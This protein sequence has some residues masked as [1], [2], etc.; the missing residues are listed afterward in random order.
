MRRTVNAVIIK[1]RKILLVEEK[2]KLSL[3]SWELSDGENRGEYLVKK[4]LANFPEITVK[5]FGHY[6]NFKEG[7]RYSSVESF[8]CILELDEVTG[9]LSNGLFVKNPNRYKTSGI[10]RKVINSL[11]QGNYLDR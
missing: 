6:G 2:G 4:I 1:E 11:K 3:P 8:V 7:N 5:R 9:K 10:T